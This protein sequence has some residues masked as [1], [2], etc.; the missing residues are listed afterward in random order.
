MAAKN[1]T[2]T[3]GNSGKTH[4]DVSSILGYGDLF[5][6]NFLARQMDIC[7]H[8]LKEHRL[9]RDENAQYYRFLLDETRSYVSQDVVE[10]LSQLEIKQSA[11]ISSKRLLV[12]KRFIPD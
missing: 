2:T 7:I 5:T 6:I 9:L 10:R 11:E 4:L 1:K 8:R 3:K 12:E